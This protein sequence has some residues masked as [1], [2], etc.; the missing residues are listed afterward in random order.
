MVATPDKGREL[1]HVDSHRLRPD[2]DAPRPAPQLPIEGPPTPPASEGGEA[3]GGDPA[4]GA[5]VVGADDDALDGP[6]GWRA[7]QTWRGA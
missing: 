2:L 6:Q 4:G 1:I 5:V 3:L 7:S